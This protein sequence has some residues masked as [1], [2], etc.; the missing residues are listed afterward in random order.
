METRQIHSRCVRPTSLADPLDG[1]II[2]DHPMEHREVIKYS[3]RTLNHLLGR[4][5]GAGSEGWLPH[6]KPGSESGDI[7]LFHKFVNFMDLVIVLRNEEGQVGPVKRV[8]T[9]VKFL[10]S[11]K[12]LDF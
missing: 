11:S 3:A 5:L 4:K 1:V 2:S 9:G 6:P 7:I 10:I 12:S 8:T